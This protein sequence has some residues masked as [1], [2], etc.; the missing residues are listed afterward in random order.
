L[1]FEKRKVDLDNSECLP[2]YSARRHWQPSVRG[3]LLTFFTSDYAAYP[4]WRVKQNHHKTRKEHQMQTEQKM[5]FNAMQQPGAE[6]SWSERMRHSK[7]LI[8][9]MAVLM[10]TTLALAAAMVGQR[11]EARNDGRSGERAE[12]IL[13]DEVVQSPQALTSETAPQKSPPVAVPAPRVVQQPVQRPVARAAEPVGN[14]GTYAAAPAA[15]VCATCG[16]VESVTAV[17]H[18]GSVNGIGNTGI[19]VGAIGGAVVGG[20]LGNQIGGGSGRKVATVLGAVGG[21]YA[22]HAIEKNANSYTAY[23]VRVRMNDGTVRTIEQ[24]TAVAAGTPVTI[25]GKPLRVVPAATAQGLR[26]G[27]GGARG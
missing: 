3:F 21:G 13:Q 27:E 8:P 26:Q 15:P 18:P 17:R 4:V 6:P 23:Q 2:N 19:G 16:T 20:L 5:P 12:T 1:A 11:I 10:V 14:P 24:P 25:G 7:A 9:T 22:G